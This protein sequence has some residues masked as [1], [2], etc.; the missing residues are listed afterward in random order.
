MPKF[1]ETGYG[2]R[3]LEGQLPQL[4][5]Q[6]EIIGNELKRANDLK[7]NKDLKKIADEIAEFE[8]NLARVIDEYLK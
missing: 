6:L 3:F 2:K 8:P 4:I 1:H 7:E 5:K